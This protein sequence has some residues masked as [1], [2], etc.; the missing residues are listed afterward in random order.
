M[1]TLA[2]KRFL[3][4]LFI[5]MSIQGLSAQKTELTTFIL[6]RHAEKAKDNP[7]DSN[8]SEIG[9]KR[10]ESLKSLLANAGITAIYST[11]YKRTQ[12]TVA[13][14]AEFLSLEIK[15]YNPR[16]MY[17]LADIFSKHNGGTILIS[18]H[19]NTTPTAVNTLLGK[20]KFEWL[21]ENEYDKVF[22][23]WKRSGFHGEFPEVEGAK[24]GTEPH[25]KKALIL[26]CTGQSVSAL[27]AQICASTS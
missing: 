10:A 3:I 14:I 22:Y 21:E 9:M 4:A 16:S 18:G 8:L 1:K 26:Y 13:P 19:S 20:E 23:N 6:V 7:R 2:M 5:I 11:P 17:F 27:Y 24:P 15:S 25:S 12:Q